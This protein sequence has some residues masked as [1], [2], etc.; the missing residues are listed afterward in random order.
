MGK[1]GC[2]E[3]DKIPIFCGEYE[4]HMIPLT[5]S[6]YIYIADKAPQAFKAADVWQ[7][8]EVL[9]RSQ[10][11]SYPASA[12]SFQHHVSGDELPESDAFEHPMP[13]A[14]WTMVSRQARLG[15]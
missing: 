1:F 4:K 10:T 5:Y 7:R 15:Q 14:I 2:C 11:V 13:N 9:A 8:I 12:L 3:N 6:T